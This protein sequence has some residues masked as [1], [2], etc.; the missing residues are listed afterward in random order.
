MPEELYNRFEAHL[1]EPTEH[2]HD[3]I[4]AVLHD[5]KLDTTSRK[6]LYSQNLNAHIENLRR[7]RERP[8]KIQTVA[9][10]ELL[11]KN[12]YLPKN[13]YATF[14]KGTPS[15][16]PSSPEVAFPFI[17]QTPNRR[18]S[19]TVQQLRR[20]ILPRVG[21]NLPNRYDEIDKAALEILAVLKEQPDIYRLGGDNQ[22][23]HPSR[24]VMLKNSKPGDAVVSLRKIL[25]A[26]VIHE[27]TGYQNF[28]R[29]LRNHEDSNELIK[30]AKR[31]ISQ[32][33][34]GW[35]VS[36]KAYK[37]SKS[38]K[39]LAKRTKKSAKKKPLVKRWGK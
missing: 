24:N 1:N 3:D 17:Y 4:T 16:A 33:G 20:P 12:I 25:G 13:P 5:K 10:P 30:A 34:R 37:K 22:F 19:Q 8:L 6:E 35:L 14:G 38:K 39:K 11:S 23:M 27:P 26:N 36:R 2:R 32:I 15:P 28:V 7:N 31:R 21:A 29:I 18:V 9:E